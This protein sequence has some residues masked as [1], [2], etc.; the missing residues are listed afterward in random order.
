MS[1]SRHL[2]SLLGAIELTVLC[3]FACK[4]RYFD[5]Q[6][7]ETHSTIQVDGIVYL[8]LRE[9]VTNYLQKNTIM[10]QLAFLI[11]SS[12]PSEKYCTNFK[13]LFLAK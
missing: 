11:V 12:T 13:P 8:P 10:K 4:T 7:K 6:I 1:F 3:A 5:A 2:Q 9:N